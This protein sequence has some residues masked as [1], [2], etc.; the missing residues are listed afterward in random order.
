VKIH[1]VQGRLPM[2]LEYLTARDIQRYARK[3]RQAT[4]WGNVKRCLTSWRDF[5]L[6]L[7]HLRIAFNMALKRL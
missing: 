1:L 6:A 4:L 7:A 2:K 5:K 3:I